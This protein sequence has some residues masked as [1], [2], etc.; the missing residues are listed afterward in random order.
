MTLSVREI[1]KNEIPYFSLRP[2]DEA[3]CVAGGFTPF[4]A[5]RLSVEG[6]QEAFALECSL[7]PL[8]LWGYR[9]RSLLG[10]VVSLWLLSSPLAD[11]HKLAFGR[12][13]HKVCY[14]LLA[15]WSVI[16]CL[17]WD[18]HFLAKHWLT[19]L[20]FTQVGAEWINGGKFLLMQK[21]RN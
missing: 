20:G 13:T 10:G 17:V 15:T 9:P 11:E 6:S 16:E 21:G 5:I 18:K 4:D 1:K 19:W 7:G 8:C 12:A 3:E 2:L 14:E